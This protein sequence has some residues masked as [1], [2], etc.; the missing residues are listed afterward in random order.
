LTSILAGR[1]GVSLAIPTFARNRELWSAR[2]ARL[3]FV[4]S[5]SR[6][7]MRFRRAAVA[8]IEDGY[9]RAERQRAMRGRLGA[10]MHLLSVGG[11]LTA[12]HR[13]DA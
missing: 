13:G 12:V 4:F 1:A 2:R 5:I 11:V 3:I 6:G 7:S 8:A 10:A 9:L